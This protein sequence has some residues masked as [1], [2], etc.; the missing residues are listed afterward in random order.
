MDRETGANLQ[1]VLFAQPELDNLLSQP[2][3]VQMTEEMSFSFTLPALD[4]DGVEAYVAHRLTKAGYSGLNIFT[5]GAINH[6]YK[7]SQGIPRLVNILAHKAMM[8]TF[9]K[10]DMVVSEANVIAAIKDTES[11]NIDRSL[12]DRL[13][14]G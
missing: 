13:F 7:G 14:A 8:A 11:A 10:G 6:L 1:V 3:L 5:S 4:R 2:A 9:G 12:L